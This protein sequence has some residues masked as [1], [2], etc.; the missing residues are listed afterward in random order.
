[1]RKIECKG[2]E[3]QYRLETA[4]K[5]NVCELKF[6]T[7]RLSQLY[8]IYILY[9][10]TKSSCKTHGIKNSLN[11]TNLFVLFQIFIKPLC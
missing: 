5:L 9:T 4:R 2:F 8:T 10:N 11:I 7:L 1:M 6:V 3:F